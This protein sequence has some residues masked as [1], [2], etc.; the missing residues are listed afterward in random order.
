M[1]SI[2]KVISPLKSYSIDRS[3]SR[4]ISRSMSRSIDRSNV[5]L[6]LQLLQDNINKMY[7]QTTN[8]SI[9]S[10][11]IDT[12]FNL[13]NLQNELQIGTFIKPPHI[14]C[15]RDYNEIDLRS[16]IDRH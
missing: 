10:D 13:S 3:M 1:Q 4:L 16:Q 9:K 2:K 7:S 8:T 14:K 6:H 15:I 11:L 12:Q 5:S